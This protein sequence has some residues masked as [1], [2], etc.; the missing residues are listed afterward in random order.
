MIP[1]RDHNPSGKTPFITYALIT[2]NT[3]I[4]IFMFSMPQAALETFIDNFA[5]IPSLV[6]SGQNTL[7]LLTSMFLHG[8]I[9]HL[10]GNML[11]LNIF[12]DNLEDALGYIKFLIYYLVA[13]LGGSF[14]Q[15][16]FDPHSTVPNLG[17]SG[18]IA[19]VMGGYLLLFPRHRVDVLFSF[20]FLLERVTV[21]AYTML[22]YWFVAQLFYGVGSLALPGNGGVAFFAH[23]GGFLTGYL[24]I[25]PF[26]DRLLR[27]KPRFLGYF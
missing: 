23:V 6:V 25:F 14:L 8:G 11:F 13:G 3:A 22:F 17:A 10:V 1:I 21:P 27:D 18:A 4:F 16:L 15:I 7:S 9:G 2:I 26:K 19:G 5:L 24:L 20:G 12:G